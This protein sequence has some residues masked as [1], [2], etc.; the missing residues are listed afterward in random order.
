MGRARASLSQAM[1]DPSILNQVASQ[2][3]MNRGEYFHG[4]LSEPNCNFCPL[5]LEAKV[6]PDGPL[7]AKIAFVGEE[8]GGLEQ[9]EG[10]GFV[11]PS[12][13]LL[14]HICKMQGIEREDIWVTNAALC[15]AKKI[16]LATGAVLPKQ[17]VKAIAAKACRLRLINELR[18]I[19]PSVVVPLGNWALWALTDIPDARIHAY[20]GSIINKDLDRLALDVVSG[21]A[22]TTMK[23]VKE[24]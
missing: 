13:Q 12:G 15:S 16:K 23:K 1:F 22:R 2:A 10:R 19:N 9:M 11:G 24:E 14:W 8:P 18:V 6:Y 5:R 17:V 21:K 4:L 20:R 3:R 7:H